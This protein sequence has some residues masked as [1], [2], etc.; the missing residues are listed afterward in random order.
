MSNE[1]RIIGI[2]GMPEVRKGDS[3]AHLIFQAVQR[4]GET[5]HSG[6]IVVVTQKIVSKAEGQVLALQDIDPSPFASQ[7]ATTLGKDPRLVEVILRQTR[8]IVRMDKGV[9]IT[10]T[11]HG[12]VC[13]NA[14]VDESN[15][16]GEA[17]VTVLPVDPDRSATEI[18]LG[19]QALFHCELAVIISDTFGRPWREG[20]TN[21]AIGVSGML[22]LKDYRGMVDPAGHTLR[23]TT[24]AIADELAAA[25]ELVMGKLDRVPV[26]LIRGYSYP[27][28]AGGIS[29]LLRLP[30]R[31]LFR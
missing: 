26:A 25:A 22:P 17:T 8:R 15:V 20:I 27:K 12:F 13:A 19:L 7:L 31:D 28:G 4:Q 11:Q 6:D 5:I 10:E 24:L 1:I 29:S 3:L 14:G 2:T 16:E 18:R 21:V 23:V 30:E 9:L